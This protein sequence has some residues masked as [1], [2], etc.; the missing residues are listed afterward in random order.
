[1]RCRVRYVTSLPNGSTATKDREVTTS[2]AR[3]RVGRGTDNDIVLKDLAVAF[4][5]ADIVVRD[6]DIVVEAVGGSAIRFDEVPAGRGALTL[7][8]VVGIGPYR[9]RLL[10][11]EPGFDLAL[12]IEAADVAP[13]MQAVPAAALRISGG[14][15]SRRP[16]SWLLFVAILAG[17]LVLPVLANLGYE[18]DRPPELAEGR[19]GRQGPASLLAGFDHAWDT[20]ELSD[21]HKFLEERCEACHVRP[22]QSISNED[23]GACHGSVRHHFDDP[24][25]LIT[26]ALRTDGHEP[27]SCTSCHAEHQGS[28][29]AVPRQQALCV[30][31]HQNLHQ[32]AEGSELAAKV[33]DFGSDHPQF[34]PSVVVDGIS[35][36][37]QRLNLDGPAPVR[38][39]SGLVFNHLCHLGL[40][41]TMPVGTGVAERRCYSPDGLLLA[42]NLP[43]PADAKQVGA[44]GAVRYQLDGLLDV[45]FPNPD[46]PLRAKL[47]CGSCHVPDAGGAGMRPVSMEQHC[48]YCH[49]LTFDRGNPERVLP[50]GKPSEVTDILTY[51]YGAAA[52]RPA[53]VRADATGQ[54]R[55]P[56]AKAEPSLPAAAPA[57]TGAAA[58]STPPTGLERRLESI[59]RDDGESTCGYCHRTTVA[60]GSEAVSYDVLPARVQKVWEPLARFD[61][62]SHTNLACGECHAAATS[63]SS[64]DVLMPPIRTC[65]ACHQGEAA[66]AAVPSTCTMCHVY[67][68]DRD[69]CPMVPSAGGLATAEGGKCAA[70]AATTSNAAAE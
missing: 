2:G 56:G 25:G 1:M 44:D 5:H 39:H 69:G 64:S 60:H 51:Y 65:R 11:A 18:R 70:P 68:Q 52:K 58:Q 26:A 3:V 49:S 10:P 33:T 67:H 36:R 43:G 9:L 8:T 54:R 6:F 61:H 30:G 19:A 24:R 53:E 27:A 34:S 66:A 50:H 40:K 48:S 23:C 57:M 62:A 31:C 22:F 28:D 46:Q 55:R 45:T 16:L 32:Y 20:G 15:A 63:S 41:T 4:R 21:P 38:E 14:I 29:G 37:V 17:C 13:A 59:F 47:S 7:E 12:S 35:G 42:K